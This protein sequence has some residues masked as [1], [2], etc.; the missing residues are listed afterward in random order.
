MAAARGRSALRQK[1]AR[2]RTIVAGGYHGPHGTDKRPGRGASRERH[3]TQVIASTATRCRKCFAHSGRSPAHSHRRV[4]HSWSEATYNALLLARRSPNQTRPAPP[5]EFWHNK[6]TGRPPRA[7]ACTTTSTSSTLNWASATYACRCE[8]LRWQ[9][10]FN[11]H[12]ALARQLDRAG[13]A[14]AQLENAFVD[15]ADFARAQALAEAYTG[16]SMA[17]AHETTAWFTLT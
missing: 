9:V 16:H 7:K 14:Y 3:D 4:F 6:A 2:C 8:A 15:L 17:A 12:H 5:G 10:Y 1:I 11:G 13:I